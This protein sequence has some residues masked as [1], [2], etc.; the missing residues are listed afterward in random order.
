[1]YKTRGEAKNKVL[2]EEF[3]KLKNFTKLSY[4]DF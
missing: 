2:K 3:K 4:F 1:M